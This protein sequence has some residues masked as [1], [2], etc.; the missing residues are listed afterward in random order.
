M[1]PPDGLAVAIDEIGGPAWYAQS[2]R[3]R[4]L[5]AAQR[6]VRSDPS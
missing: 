2:N 1:V 5:A 3:E 4:L 6:Q